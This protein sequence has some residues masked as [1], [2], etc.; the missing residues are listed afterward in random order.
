MPDNGV[1]SCLLSYAGPR[2][3][4]VFSLELVQDIA[5]KRGFMFPVVLIGILSD[6]ILDTCRASD[7]ES[8]AGCTFSPKTKAK[9]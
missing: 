8:N 9:R 6:E 4:P 2:L 3:I 1:V 7:P 5:C